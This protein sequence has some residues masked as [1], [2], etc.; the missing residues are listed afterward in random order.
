[1]DNII[2]KINSV[3]RLDI[4]CFP[5]PIHRMNNVEKELCQGQGQVFI[6]RDDLTGIGPGGNKIRF[7]EYILQD[8]KQKDSDVVLVS[9]PVQSNLCTATTCVCRKINMECIAVFNGEKPKELKGNFLLDEIIDSKSHYIGDVTEEERNVYVEDLSKLLKS[10]GKK[11]Y[12]IRYGG[13]TGLGAMGYVNAIIELIEQCESHNIK[14]D[15]IFAPGANGGVA[16][17]LIYGNAILGFPFKINIISVE[18]D[19]SLLKNNII[20]II[21]EL[22]ILTGIKFNYNLEE[23]CK[24]FDEF[25]GNGWG[26]R[27]EKSENLVYDFPK[28][29]G[30]FIENIYTSKVLVGMLELIKNRK[31]NGNA[32]FIHTGGFVSLFGQI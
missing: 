3:K 8:A 16:A 18:Y 32:C 2:A 11:P 10:H 13:S 24:I 4:G 17:G 7:L 27:T 25:R 19:T 15:E 14:I 6:K 31:V 28:M 30:I 5:T 23:A 1:M 29:E 22:E 12:I 21:N 26:Y 20:K 9:G